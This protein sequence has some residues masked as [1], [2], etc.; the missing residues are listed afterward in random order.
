MYYPPLDNPSSAKTFNPLALQILDDIPLEKQFLEATNVLSDGREIIK[1]GIPPC[2]KLPE[3][4]MVERFTC[5]RENTL[6]IFPVKSFEDTINESK[7]V[8]FEIPL[9]ILDF[10]LF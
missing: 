1:S 4:S 2:N 6:L 9:G 10:I 5:L 8:R 3:I 7:L